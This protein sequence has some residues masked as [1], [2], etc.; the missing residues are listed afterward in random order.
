MR[1][2]SETRHVSHLLSELPCPWGVAGGWAVDLFLDRMTREHQDIE[3][4]M[5]R[6]DQ[7]ILQDYLWCRGWTC[8]YIRDGHF[9]PWPKRESLALPIH[10]I[11]CRSDSGPLLRLEVLLNQR[12][13][14]AFVFRRDSRIKTPIERTFVQS[15]SSIPI[16]APE[17]VLLYKSKRANEDKEQLDFS[18]IVGALGAERRQWLLK[19]IETIDPAHCW[20]AAL[21][22][23]S[24]T[25]AESR[26]GVE[27]YE[28]RAQAFLRQTRLRNRLMGPQHR[29]RGR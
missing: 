24:A 2:F 29:S 21:R 20:L 23:A 1:D 3:I 13:T 19:S 5:F 7:L 9:H 25:D 4:A 18:N 15:N 10:E 17:I 22:G 8:E 26:P 16:L 6:E 11:W 27:Q 14:D 28:R 12:V